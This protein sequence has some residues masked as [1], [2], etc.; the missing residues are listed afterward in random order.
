MRVPLL[1]LLEILE[2]AER[3][4]PQPAAAGSVDQ[5]PTRRIG[6]GEKAAGECLICL[7]DFEEGSEVR[8]LPC[9]HFFHTACVDKWLTSNGSCPVCKHRVEADGGEQA[10]LTGGAGAAGGT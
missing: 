5:L 4:R 10:A 8:T 2:Q 7:D 6:E 3:D 9:F 1:D